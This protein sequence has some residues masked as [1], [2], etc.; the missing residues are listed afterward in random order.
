MQVKWRG[1]LMKISKIT[2]RDIVDIIAMEKIC[3]S[4]RLEEIYFLS[5]L[6]DLTAMPSTDS[7]FDDAEGD[8]WQHRI[9]NTDWE[10]SWV[11]HDDRFGLESGGDDLF[12]KFLCETIHPA[13]RS[14]ELEVSRITKLYNQCL[15]RDGFEIFEKSRLSGKPVFDS[16]FVGVLGAPNINTI[17]SAV[18][19]MDENYVSQQISRM[20]SSVQTDP[21]LA[22]GTAK[23]LVE[24]CCKTIL[25]GKGV[26]YSGLDLPQLVKKTSKELSLTPDDIPDRTKAAETIKRLLSNLANLVKGIAELRNQFGTGHGRSSNAKGLSSRHARLAVGAAST[27]ATFLLETNEL[28]NTNSK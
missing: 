8:I 5:R 14:D 15:R 22:I 7:R 19:L 24:T 21:S 16:R 20:E 28:R 18:S 1:A 10:D 2:R 12:L 11:F 27:L 3:W 13:V 25:N 4:G 6:Y 17:K 26:E 23:E 9:N